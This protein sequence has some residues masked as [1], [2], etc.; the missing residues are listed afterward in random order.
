MRVRLW[1]TVSVFLF[2]LTLSAQTTTSAPIAHAWHPK[3]YPISFWCAPD[4]EST[5][6]E[7]YQQIKDAGFTFVMPPCSGATVE[8]N[9]KILD[10]CQQ[11]GL[12]AFI[13]DSRVV[14]AGKG[15]GKLE[16]VDDAVK[17]YAS[18]PALAGYMV[19]DEPL[20]SAFPQLAAVV[21]RLR[22]KDPAHVAFINLFPNVVAPN[23]LKARS[24]DD[25]M[26]RFV[27]T[28]RPFTL[29]YDHYSLQKKGDDR[30]FI[31]NLA[32]ARQVALDGHVP[33][34][35]IVQVTEWGSMR[36]LTQGEIEYQAM[37]SLAMGA[38]GLLWFTYWTPTR[39]HSQ[40]WKHAMI[41][42]DGK[43]DAH[44][45]M[46]KQTNARLLA[47]GNE[48]LH[49]TSVGFF[50]TGKVPPGGRAPTKEAPV[51]FEGDAP[52]MT[53]GWFDGPDGEPLILFASGDYKS[54]IDFEASIAGTDVERFDVSSKA[55]TKTESSKVKVHLE[56]GSAMLFRAHH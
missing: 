40:A 34:W 23:L 44:Y 56:P 51:T 21:D 50:Q 6:L 49:A 5:N 36:N 33:F 2:S 13:Q 48:L 12:K 27:E 4:A 19:D 22:E 28:V 31:A 11:V 45:D 37:Q 55:W 43:P 24:Y 47:I 16:E 14:T 20:A 3:E 39:D 30:L 42:A 38:K 32:A 52:P 17:A 1:I 35:N 7:R 8:N 54:A 9:H 41:D 46:V 29:S 18:H 10:L 25:Y 53:V 26:R 15:K